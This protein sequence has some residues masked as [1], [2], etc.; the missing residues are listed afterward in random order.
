M[1]V[2]KYHILAVLEGFVSVMAKIRDGEKLRRGMS[3]EK[4]SW[5]DSN[6]GRIMHLTHKDLHCRTSGSPMTTTWYW[7]KMWQTS[8]QKALMSSLSKITKCKLNSS[9]VSVLLPYLNSSKKWLQDKYL[10]VRQSECLCI[11]AS[12][13]QHPF[14]SV[15]ISFPTPE[16]ILSES[17]FSPFQSVW[18]A[19]CN[20]MKI[21]D[22]FS[23]SV[24]RQPT[25]LL[26]MHWRLLH[27]TE[28]VGRD[29]DVPNHH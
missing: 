20:S 25:T 21:K 12:L 19:L 24:K 4:G 18:S 28:Y 6:P 9:T 5:L 26:S 7:C 14:C 23:S 27:C 10:S 15:H 17:V 3:L 1:Q 2:I 11:Y 29:W 13:F 8:Y 16:K 22:T